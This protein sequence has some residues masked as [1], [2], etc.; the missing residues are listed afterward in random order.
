MQVKI[1]VFLLL[2]GLA[3]LVKADKYYVFFSDKKGQ[4]L[5]P[6]EYFHPKAIERRI[7]NDIPLVQKS[8][9]PVNPNYIAQ[10]A[11]L[12]DSL[13]AVSRWFNMVCVYASNAQVVEIEELDF[14]NKIERAAELS[15]VITKLDFERKTELKDHLEYQT[16][17]MEGSLFREHDVFGKGI[18]IAVLDAGFTA[19]DVNSSL[20]HLDIVETYDFVKNEVSPYKGSSHGTAVLSS[21]GG[22]SK[23]DTLMGL[24]PDASYLLARTERHYREVAAEEEY[25]LAAA[26][27]ADKH[28]ADVINSSLGYTNNRYFLE[29]MNGKSLVAR[30]ANKAFSKGIVVVVSVGNDGD[31]KW[32]YLGTPADADSALAIGGLDP[33]S[34][35]KIDF[36]SYGPNANGVMKP[37]LCAA[38]A[39]MTGVGSS[40]E[41]LSYGT[42]FSSP[43]VAGFVACYLQLHPKKTAKEVF[44]DVQACGH[45]Y[46]YYDFA[47]GYGAPLASKAFDIYKT[48]FPEFKIVEDT[49]YNIFS[50]VPLDSS[51]TREQM[52]SL[53]KRKNLFF[54]VET[55]SGKVVHY[56]VGYARYQPLYYLTE[57]VN[58]GWPDVNIYTRT[59]EIVEVGKKYKLIVHLEGRTEE[60][61]I[62]WK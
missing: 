49:Q 44:E 61:M 24:A 19:A 10:I 3:Q 37:N 30:A 16:E 42:S 45:L 11:K 47:H 51:I 40:N 29:D 58:D 18:R 26:E 6:Y 28:G 13:T 8:D 9:L 14:V 34:D 33:Y 4:E 23:S 50:I 54:K 56:N 31:S 39:A 60:L 46:P 62:K 59:E 25:W 2:V 57:K 20:S 32:K 48:D 41:R 15:P 52:R 27:W 12:S 35:R 5:D 17:R 1:A 22:K 21:I 55:L 7:K 53:C 36:S 43:L 38:G